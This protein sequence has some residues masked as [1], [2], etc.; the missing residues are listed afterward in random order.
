MSA[1]TVQRGQVWAPV[2]FLV[3]GTPI[4]VDL[5]FGAFT[6]TNLGALVPTVPAYGFA[7]L[8]I[9]GTARRH[10]AGWQAVIILGI[11]FSVIAECLI[12]QTSLSPSPERAWG[13]AAGVNWTYLVWTMGYFSGWC[14]PLSIQLTE[15]VFPQHRAQRWLTPLGMGVVAIAFVGMGI[16]TGYNWTHVTAPRM[17]GLPIYTPPLST[18][19]AA[20]LAAGCLI[21]LGV[22]VARRPLRSRTLA[23]RPAPAPF[24]VTVAGLVAG[25]L[26]FVLLIPSVTGGA[27]TRVPPAVAIMA[28]STVA[29]ATATVVHH[30]SRSRS[31]G[32]QHRLALVTGAMTASMGFGFLANHLTGTDLF[33]KVV[34]NVA[35][36]LGLAFIASRLRS[37]AV[38]DDRTRLLTRDGGT[39]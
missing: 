9:R 12:V 39:P 23:D 29:V 35:A 27:L 8:L 14:I 15:L 21:V 25:G 30:W 19:G 28:A 22:V 5:L 24:G 33:G 32:D 17:T 20:A 6:V 36:L 1:P 13:R 4:V 7:A 37:R 11:A 18:L 38:P 16:R 10:G 34:L 26:W 2:L 3:L 31:W